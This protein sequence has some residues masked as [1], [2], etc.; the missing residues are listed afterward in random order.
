[1]FEWTSLD[2]VALERILRTREQLDD[3]LAV[4]L[5]PHQLDRARART[6]SLLDLRAQHLDRLRRRRSHRPDRSGASAASTAASR[7]DPA[8]APPGS[9][10]RAS[11][12][13]ARSASSTTAPRRRCTVSRAGSC[14]AS[15]P[16]RR[17]PRCVSQFTHPPPLLAE[18]QGNAA[19]APN[20]DWFVGWGQVPDFSEF[21]PAGQLLFD[22]HFPPRHAVLPQRIASRGPACRGIPRR[23]P[24]QRAA[25]G[26]GTVYASWNGATLVAAW[27]V[28]VGASATALAAESRRP[29]AAALRPRSRC[30]RAPS[31]PIVAVQALDAGGAVIGTSPTKI[32]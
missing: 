32:V 26:A 27:R 16:S 20:G 7:W 10:T 9:T 25:G 29:R 15:I 13:T 11:S 4:R 17:R 1:M 5:L 23:S 24:F 2:H 19:G 21:S 28:L 6:A 22:A 18:S 31:G 14:S 30:P 3:E 12:P 8:R